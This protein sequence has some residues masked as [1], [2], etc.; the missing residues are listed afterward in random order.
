MA[1]YRSRTVSTHS[2]V[3]YAIFRARV[4]YRTV[5]YGKV[6]QTL[7]HIEENR[8]TRGVSLLCSIVPLVLAFYVTLHTYSSFSENLIDWVLQIDLVSQEM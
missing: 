7:F 5:P 4:M 2:T 3:P 8:L 6:S 1:H